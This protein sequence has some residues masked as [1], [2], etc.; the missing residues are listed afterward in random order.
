[1]TQQPEPFAIICYAQC[2]SCQFGYCY[3]PPEAHRWAGAE[4]IEHAAATGQPEPTGLCA[5][6]CAHPAAEQA[7][8]AP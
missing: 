2:E 7:T 3:E 8:S 6:R 1:M 4:D 5:C